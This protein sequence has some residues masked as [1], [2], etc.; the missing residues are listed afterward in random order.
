MR[1]DEE[2]LQDVLAAISKVAAY[3]GLL[4]TAE[5]VQRNVL[6][7]AILHQ[8][9]VVGEA[10]GRLSEPVKAQ[11]P[12]VNWQRVKGLRNVITH[13]YHRVEMDI[14]WA[15]VD[16]HFPALEQAARRLLDGLTDQDEAPPVG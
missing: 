12:E 15:A 7:D 1:R 4:E 11:A 8:L 2:H 14:V 13:E 3:R 10:V 9:T 16:N 6:E 5:G